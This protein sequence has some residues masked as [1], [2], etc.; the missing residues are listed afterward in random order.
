MDLKQFM[1][2]ILIAALVISV[3]GL[4]IAGLTSNYDLS[5]TETDAAY[6]PLAIQA[7]NTA[8]AM[9]ETANG[10]SRLFNNTQPSVLG[11]LND[12]YTAAG[13]TAKMTI[14]SIGLV[15]G[16]LTTAVTQFGWASY[17]LMYALTA[18]VL[19]IIISI[20]YLVLFGKR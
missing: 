7:N 12:L 11:S 13:G 17:L 19:T 6:G 3:F 18:L 14:S 4:V 5:T 20:A 2:G 9:N 8:T 1:I 15:F 10:M 16:M